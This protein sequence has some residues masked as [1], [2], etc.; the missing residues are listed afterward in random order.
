MYVSFDCAEYDV[1]NQGSA[2][3]HMFQPVLHLFVNVGSYILLLHIFINHF[4][5]IACFA[6][7]LNS[8]VCF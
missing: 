1:G 6:C 3:F 2:I 8:F 7:I 4:Q 5:D